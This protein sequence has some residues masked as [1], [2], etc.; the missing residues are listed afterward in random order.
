M[1]SYLFDEFK[2][3]VDDAE[4]MDAPS[5]KAVLEKVSNILENVQPLKRCTAVS[6]KL[7]L[8]GTIHGHQ[9]RLC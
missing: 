7:G 5:K 3:I 1:I 4:W 8:K 2:K 6:C 9:D